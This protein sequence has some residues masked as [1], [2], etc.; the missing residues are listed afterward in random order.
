MTRRFLAVMAMIVGA[1]VLG[2]TAA[3][4]CGDKFV[5]LGRGARVAARNTPRRS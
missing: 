3:S 1:M 2:E 4:A 5:L